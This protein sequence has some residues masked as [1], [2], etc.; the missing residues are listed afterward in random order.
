MLV[1]RQYKEKGYCGQQRLTRYIEAVKSLEIE[2]DA[3][4][5]SS[6]FADH[7]ARFPKLLRLAGSF[8][9]ITWQIS[10]SAQPEQN[11]HRL[12]DRL[13]LHLA[14]GDPYEQ[15]DGERDARFTEEGE[16]RKLLSKIHDEGLV[17]VSGCPR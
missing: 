2:I 7:R 11:G 3:E 1:S 8:S 14:R 10:R 12:G 16:W 15:I 4:P 5:S 9:C 17:I 6:L 13:E